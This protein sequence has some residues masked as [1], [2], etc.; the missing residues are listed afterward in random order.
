MI[1]KDCINLKYLKA[2]LLRR[3]WYIVLPFFAISIATAGYCIKTPGDYKAETLILVDRQKAPQEHI[4]STMTVDLGDRLRT[5]TR[6]IKSREMLEKIINEYD[7]YPD[8]RVARTMMDAVDVFQKKIEINIRDFSQSSG[9]DSFEIAYISD[10]PVKARDVTNAI[11]NLFIEDNLKPIESEVTGTTPLIDDELERMKEVLRQKE[12]QV[13]EF[14]EKYLGLT[15]EQMEKNVRTLTKLQQQINSLNKTIQQTKEQK[16]L[17]QTK[18]S[19]L[20]ESRAD[21]KEA[22]GQDGD[23]TTDQ[24]PLT[25]EEL[26]LQLQSLKSRYSNKHPDVIRLV[27]TIAKLEK[28]QNE[29]TALDSDTKG[30]S[31]Q[32]FTSEAQRHMRRMLVQRKDFLSQL[33]LIDK[34]LATLEKKKKKTRWQIAQYRKRVEEGPKIEQKS[35]DLRQNLRETRENYQALLDKR[36]QAQLPENLER[37]SQ[38]EQLRILAPATLPEKPVK[39]NHRKI[40]AL[41]FLIAIACGFGLAFSREYLDPTFFSSNQLESIV[42]LPVLVSIPIVN[43]KKEYRWNIL[44]RAGAATALVSMVSVLFYALFILWKTVPATF[45]FPLG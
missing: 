21:T 31:I 19:K 5:I 38:G 4:E 3:F 13:Q 32:P 17:L 39:P 6:Q 22:V 9:T 35:V 44:K 20:E 24:E 10:D 2:A 26:R 43:T 42:K 25:L 14:E 29:S 36:P 11:A 28:E 33:K 8:V 12:E 40:L 7:L 37:A 45:R 1:S 27:A 34:Q 18:L 15:P 41:G 16:V 30:T 23:L